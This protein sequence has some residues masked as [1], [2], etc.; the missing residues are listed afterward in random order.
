MGLA[1]VCLLDEAVL[2]DIAQ[3]LPEHYVYSDVK[4]ALKKTFNTG[5][6]DHI[7]RDN[8]LTTRFQKL[9]S[10]PQEFQSKVAQL[11]HRGLI[12]VNDVCTALCHA[13]ALHKDLWHEFSGQINGLTKISD[14]VTQVETLPHLKE[15]LDR[16]CSTPRKVFV[17]P[18]APLI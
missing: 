4:K 9:D 14:V 12:T 16:L 10:F 18:D 11:Q 15:Q 13:L 5:A 2:V 6:K 8:F 17:E 3:H 7:N 1:C